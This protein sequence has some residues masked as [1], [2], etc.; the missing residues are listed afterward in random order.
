MQSIT[1]YETTPKIVANSCALIS[2]TP[3]GR[4]ELAA[5]P[6]NIDVEIQ[7]YGTL[8]CNIKILNI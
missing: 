2:C 5:V 1:V 6:C 3:R 4:S 8:K 7:Q